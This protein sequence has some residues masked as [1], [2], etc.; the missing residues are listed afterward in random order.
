MQ[1]EQKG[2]CEWKNVF[3]ITSSNIYIFNS[4][5]LF[6]LARTF[7]W[8]WENSASLHE[9]IKMVCE[10]GSK[11]NNF[12]KVNII[13]QLMPARI[14]APLLGKLSASGTHKLLSLILIQ[15]NCRHGFGIRIRFDKA[16]KLRI[17]LFF[18]LLEKY[19]H[20]HVCLH[21]L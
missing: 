20:T 13:Y 7:V 3:N 21:C 19:T 1:R 4:S 2:T 11:S 12:L 18:F 6:I 16:L 9:W 10:N 17:I 14:L 8:F 5:K 15:S